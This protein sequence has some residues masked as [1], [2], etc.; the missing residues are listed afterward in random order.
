MKYWYQKPTKEISDYVRTV[1]IVEGFS[2]LSNTKTPLVTN[3]TST[4][5]CRTEKCTNKTEKIVQLTLFGQST[6][7]EA[8]ELSKGT[9]L[10]VYL[11]N[12]FTVTP[13]FNISAAKLIKSPVELANWNAHKTNALKTQ[14]TYADTTARKIEILDNLLIHQLEQ[15]KIECE[16]IRYATD[17]IMCNTDPEILPTILMNLGINERT[18]QRRFK[19]YVGITAT[20]YRRICQFQL[21]F[22]QVKG[23]HF[24]TLTDVA[25]NNGFADQNHFIRSFKEFTQMTPKDYIKSGLKPKKR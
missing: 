19:K 18:F 13:L 23:K 25:Y 1:L 21:S 10:I 2:K 15:N 14:L 16:S 9:T 12:P 11:F 7:A 17:E 22:S 3:G 6:P 8:L 5:F 24:D 4:L 20:Q